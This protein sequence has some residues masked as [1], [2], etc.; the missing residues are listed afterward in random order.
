[1]TAVVAL[2]GVLSLGIPDIP[3][4]RGFYQVELSHRGKIS[5]DEENTEVSTLDLIGFI[6]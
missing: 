3:T 2:F 4:G 6:G 1:M 5:E